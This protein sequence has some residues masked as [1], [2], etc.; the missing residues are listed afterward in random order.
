MRWD[1]YTLLEQRKAMS[2]YEKTLLLIAST[3][4]YIAPSRCMDMDGLQQVRSR[5][6]PSMLSRPQWAEPVDLSP[7]EDKNISANIT[8]LLWSWNV[9][10]FVR[11]LDQCLA[12]SNDDLLNCAEH[13]SEFMV[14]HWWQRWTITFH[15]SIMTLGI[16]L[17]H[18]DGWGLSLHCLTQMNN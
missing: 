10:I 15:T 11:H 18:W 2:K 7:A 1:F 9:S 17:W 8:R 5:A 13:S 12:R 3:L 4:A 14:L 16:C 6:A